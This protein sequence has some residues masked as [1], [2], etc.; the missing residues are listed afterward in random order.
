MSK[1]GRT[2]KAQGCLGCGGTGIL[3]WGAL[4]RHRGCQTFNSDEEARDYAVRA[5]QSHTSLIDRRNESLSALKALTEWCRTHT[6]PLQPNSPHEL[7]IAACAVIG[8]DP[9]LDN[10]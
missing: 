1:G 9:L 7:L 8:I 4:V 3:G 10:T 5:T 2:N 6:S